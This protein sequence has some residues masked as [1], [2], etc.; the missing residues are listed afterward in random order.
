MI[1]R[2]RF[3]ADLVS[4]RN[5]ANFS[6]LTVPAGTQKSTVKIHA[7]SCPFGTV[8]P[9]TACADNGLKE[10]GYS[11]EFSDGDAATDVSGNATLT[12]V[13]PGPLTIFSGDYSSPY[14]YLVRCSDQAGGE[15]PADVYF[16]G[17][18]NLDLPGG[19]VVDCFWIRATAPANFG[20]AISSASGTVGSSLNIIV[21]GFPPGQS[22]EIDWDG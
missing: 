6:G 13:L 11:V 3:S 18:F 16:Y 22:V 1:G 7:V 2:T 20:I 8:D 5:S 14:P 12:G 19:A 15:L 17:S 4:V 10:I 21:S 9:F